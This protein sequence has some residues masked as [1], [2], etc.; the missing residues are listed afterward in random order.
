MK[1]SASNISAVISTGPTPS[2][3]RA[4]GCA[5]TISARVPMTSPITEP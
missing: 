4:R 5:K 2:A 1:V 3:N